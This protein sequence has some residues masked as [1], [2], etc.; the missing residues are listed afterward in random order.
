MQNPSV[1][2]WRRGLWLA[3]FLPLAIFALAACDGDGDNDDDDGD[4]GQNPQPAAVDD[5]ATTDAGAAVTV[6]VL[7]NDS[8]LGDGVASLTVTQAPSNGTAAVT[9]QN[10][11]TYTPDAGFSGAESFQ[12]RVTDN[13]G[14][15]A[16]ATVTVRVG[17]Q[18]P[19]VNADSASTTAGT[20]VTIDLLA[21]D[22]NL[23]TGSPGVSV[24]L[25]PRDG[26]V[27]IGGGGQATYT[28]DAGFVGSDRFDYQVTT[29]SGQSL[30]ATVT[31]SVNQATASVAVTGR[32]GFT[33]DSA[34]DG[35]EVVIAAVPPEAVQAAA[36]V[37]MR[38]SSTA[39]LTKGQRQLLGDREV[40][41][42]QAEASVTTTT[43]SEGGFSATLAD[44]GVPTRIR[45]EISYA[46][47]GA[48]VAVA[49]T[50]WAEVDETTTSV[51]IGGLTIA[52]PA[53][54]E[55]TIQG[56]SAQ[57]EDGEVRFSDLPPEIDRLFAQGFDP[58]DQG[59]SGDPEAAAD[60]DAFPGAFEEAGSIPL[61]SSVFA[62]TEAVDADGNPVDDLSE[63]TRMRMQV[64]PGQWGDLEDINTGTD[65]IEIPI[66]AFDETTDTWIEEP[67]GGWLEDEMGTVLPEEAQSLILDGSFEGPLF[68]AFR[69]DHFSYMNVDYPFIGPWT[70]SRLDRNRRNN[71]CLADAMNL[72]KTIALSEAGRSAYAQLNVAD[73]DLGEE[74]ADGAGPELKS[75]DL[76]GD[77]GE[78][79]GNEDGDRDD[80]FYMGDRLWEACGNDATDE[81]ERNATFQM[82]VTILHETAHWK[83]DVKHEGGDWINPEP[84]G[85]AGHALEDALFG[86]TIGQSGGP[87]TDPTL[88]GTAVSDAQRDRWLNPRTWI[89][90][91]GGNGADETA[92]GAQQ[93]DPNSPLNMQ[94]SLD[95]ANYEL[96]DPIIATIEYRN[97]GAE[98]IEVLSN[99]AL[100]GY[101]LWFEIYRGDANTRVPFR[102]KRQRLEVD[103]E[104]DFFTLAPGAT[105]TLSVNLLR[106]PDTDEL[107]YNLL[108]TGQYTVQAFYSPHWGL[109]ESG[110]NSVGFSVGGGGSI[111]GTVSNAQDGNALAEATVRVLRDD[112]ELTTATTGANGR[113]RVPELPSGSYTVEAGA[114]GFLRSSRTEISVETGAETTV[115]FSLS[116]LLTVGQLR[117]V[118]SWGESPSDLDSHLWLPQEVPYHV[119]FGRRGQL[120]ECPFAEL[121]TDDTSSFGPETITIG[122]RVNGDYRYAVFNFSGSPALT[123]SEAEVQVFDASGL[124]TTF[125]VPTDGEGRWWHVMDIDGETGAITQVD[126]IV[127]SSPEL[128][129]DT[130]MG[131]EQLDRQ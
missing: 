127:S 123:T 52:D 40:A 84:G 55:V 35:A 23:G 51:D 83:W 41:A 107:R 77:Y 29:Q 80:Q 39:M 56:N 67:Q 47:E 62:W 30:S 87:G 79:R 90:A 22:S 121:D 104:E 69:T 44:I 8:G 122:Q 75:G 18:P 112:S 5:N 16:T 37:R 1:L 119:Y 48:V 71:S 64:P 68:A 59:A 85:E 72:A 100:E 24:L 63:A 110:S 118:L 74:L 106:D 99:R 58:G 81:Q 86:G 117:I 116:P 126:E 61:N 91:G 17:D 70:L 131:C 10:Q 15:T 50:R 3:V 6:D 33:D 124:V 4:G 102:G 88:D 129:Q 12:Y 2:R 36:A 53:S 14:D 105:E 73:A 57:T 108:Q 113:Y 38:A 66:Y 27:Q 7:G 111:A 26:T 19:E 46:P 21:N 11:I 43:D 125:N 49:Q 76:G 34:V 28:P 97:V 65:R 95:A 93:V 96:G 20:A 94:L 89:D 115:N 32:L 45:V 103:Y 9:A 130:A 13:N 31:V 78:F 54:T 60:A 42:A 109:P 98:P 128:Y 82:A 120:G 92:R 114:R 101:P 25:P